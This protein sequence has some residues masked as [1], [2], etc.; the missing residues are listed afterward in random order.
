MVDGTDA[1]LG[2]RLL[3]S[4]LATA[5]MHVGHA[6][7]DASNAR[8]R[9]GAVGIGRREALDTGSRRAIWLLRGRV[10]S[11]RLCVLGRI[12]SI[13]RL[14]GLRSAKLA[15]SWQLTA[16]CSV[17]AASYVECAGSVG[18]LLLLTS[19]GFC[20]WRTCGGR[21]RGG[22]VLVGLAIVGLLVRDLALA[23][24]VGCRHGGHREASG[25][26]LT[27][28]RSTGLDCEDG[29]IAVSRW[30]AEPYKRGQ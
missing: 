6:L 8:C 15:S 28:V 29:G 12:A 3:G 24:V 9:R 25:G 5:H 11:S 19:G 10:S 16:C 13:A 30:A 22:W 20:P 2:G 17:A 18:S 4:W 26:H 21:R 7:S 23:V 14:E 1:C 27:W